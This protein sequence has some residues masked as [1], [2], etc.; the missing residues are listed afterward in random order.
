MV[1]SVVVQSERHRN[2]ANGGHQNRRTTVETTKKK[3]TTVGFL[4]FSFLVCSTG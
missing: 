1:W 2:D 4:F 3:K